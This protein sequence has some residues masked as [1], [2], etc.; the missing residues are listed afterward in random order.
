MQAISSVINK[1]KD[2]YLKAVQWV[3]NHPHITMWSAFGAIVLGLV[4]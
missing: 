3:V 1:V 4:F 2:G